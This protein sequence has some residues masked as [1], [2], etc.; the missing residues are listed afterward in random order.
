MSINI[1]QLS[2]V[3]VRPSLRQEVLDAF[4]AHCIQFQVTGTLRTAHFMAQVCHESNGFRVLVENMNY[5]NP[6]RLMAIWPRRFPTLEFA[7]QYTR[8]PAKLGNFVYANRLGNGSPASGD[9]FRYRGRGPMQTTGKDWY[10]AVSRKIF[11]DDRL[12]DQ[13]DLLTVVDHG[14]M[15]AFI[16][17]K[18]GNCNTLADADDLKAITRKINGGLIGLDGRKEWL[19]D[20]KHA[21]RP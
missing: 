6:H 16:E 9:G 18:D 2:E 21:L 12:I 13:P 11:G 5:I 10:R 19:M 3:N 7:S 15:A 8:N 20:W 17:W 1:S 14:L 4:N